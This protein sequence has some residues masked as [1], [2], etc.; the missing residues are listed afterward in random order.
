MNANKFE[1]AERIS[2]NINAALKSGNYNL[3]AQLI[4]QAQRDNIIELY[5]DQP[6]N[7]P[8]IN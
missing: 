6:L 8:Q 3:A 7:T 2:Q 1:E 4:S 5:Y